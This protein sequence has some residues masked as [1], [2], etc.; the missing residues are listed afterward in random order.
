MRVSTKVKFN[1]SFK[2]AEIHI[3]NQ[4]SRALYSE[5]ELIMARSKRDFVPVVSG[6]LRASGFVQRPRVMH[7][8]ITVEMGYGGPAATY[9][10][11]VHE[12][13]PTHGQGKSG[14]LSKPLN[15]H[16]YDLLARLSKKIK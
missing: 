7:D 6:N 4:V 5:A 8:A 10:L 9:A 12:A 1:G 15:A 13:P 14:Y 16:S 11:S 3:I 2:A